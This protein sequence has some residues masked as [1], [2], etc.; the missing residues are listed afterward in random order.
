MVP[1]IAPKMSELVQ[2]DEYF[3]IN[4]LMLRNPGI[5]NFLDGCAISIP[6][7]QPIILQLG[8][9]QLRLQTMIKSY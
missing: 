8:L 5:F 1:M 3:R 9:R 6:N 4:A 7:H 2:D